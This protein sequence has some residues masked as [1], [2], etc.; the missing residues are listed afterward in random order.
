LNDAARTC[1]PNE[2]SQNV[3]MAQCSKANTKINATQSHLYE[4]QK[5]H[6]RITNS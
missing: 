1:T 6:I 2:R 4:T 5:V 3:N